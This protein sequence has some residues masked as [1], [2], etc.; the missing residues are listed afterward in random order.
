MAGKRLLL[1]LLR[2]K[3]FYLLMKGTGPPVGHRRVEEN[4]DFIVKQKIEGGSNLQRLKKEKKGGDY[5]IQKIGLAY[6]ERAKM[7]DGEV[8]GVEI[9]Y[10]LF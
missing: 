3:K 4:G 10:G 1:A 7:R 9:F 8:L 2:S 6:Q 5:S